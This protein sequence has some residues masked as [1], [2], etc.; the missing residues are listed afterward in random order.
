MT[1]TTTLY[2]TDFYTWTTQTVQ[3]LKEQRFSELDLES[4]IEEIEGL[5]RSEYRALESR[6]EVLLMHL[7][8]VKYQPEMHNKSWDLTVKEQRLRIQRLLRDNPGLKPKLSQ[9]WEDAWEPALIQAQQETGL[10]AAAF[11]QTNPFNLEEAIARHE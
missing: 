1:H 4:L 7:L 10:D 5:G 9:V 11:P 2:D 6:L 8:K 3:L